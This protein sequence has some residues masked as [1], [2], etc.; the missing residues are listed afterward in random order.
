MAVKVDPVKIRLKP[1]AR[2]KR[3]PQPKW[4]YGAKMNVMTK[5]AKQQLKSGMFEHA[6]DSPWASRPHIAHKAIR[7]TSKDDDVFDVRIVGDYVYVNSY[8]FRE[9]SLII[10][11][12]TVKYCTRL[13][14]TRIGTQMVTNS[15]RAGP[16]KRVLEIPWQFGP[17]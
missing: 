14:N 4:G 2:P 10:M 3:C 13:V 1:N 6:R 15:T 8:K 11:M 12:R 17:L 16:L 7:G 9:A 5:W